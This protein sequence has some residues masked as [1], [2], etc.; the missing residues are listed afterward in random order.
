MSESIS[1]EIWEN[2]QYKYKNWIA[3]EKNPW[4]FKNYD[5]CNPPD[6]VLLPLSGEW[7]WVSN[8]RIDR[9]PG[10][11][12]PDGWDYAI[13]LQSYKIYD[14]KP[15]VEKTWSTTVRRRLWSRVMRREVNTIL[16]ITDWNV[17][18][19]KIQNSLSSIHTTRIRIEEIVNKEP[20]AINSDQLL[21]AITIVKKQISDIT[22]ALD[23]FDEQHQQSGNKSGTQ[24]LVIK[25]LKNDVTKELVRLT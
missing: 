13:R 21:S 6:E 19:P 7:T 18:L 14:R 9:S 17:A 23:Q 10:M 2:Q 8:W 3:H 25:K 12:D 20:E 16:K 11:T 4:T 22:N 1:I 24:S 5:I 15:C